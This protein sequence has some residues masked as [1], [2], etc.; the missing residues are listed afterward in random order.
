[1]EEKKCC[2]KLGNVQM[3]NAKGGQRLTACEVCDY[4]YF[5]LGIGW[6]RTCGWDSYPMPPACYPEP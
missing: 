5:V 3:K 1:M 6:I 2:P 4:A